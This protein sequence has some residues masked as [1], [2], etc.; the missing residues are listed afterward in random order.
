MKDAFEEDL[1]VSSA[2][3]SDMLGAITG[4]MFLSRGNW[5]PNA[6]CKECFPFSPPDQ[7]TSLFLHFAAP[8]LRRLSSKDNRSLAPDHL[9]S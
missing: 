1:W 4:S 9:W 6:W 2:G 5:S 8:H 7:Y 3:L